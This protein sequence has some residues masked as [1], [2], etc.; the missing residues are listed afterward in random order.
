MSKKKEDLEAEVQRLL[1]MNAKTVDTKTD[2]VKPAAPMDNNK[3]NKSGDEST[4]LL[5]PEDGAPKKPWYAC[6]T[7]SCG[8]PFNACGNPLSACGSC[9]SYVQ[10]T[11]GVMGSWIAGALVALLIVYLSLTFLIPPGDHGDKPLKFEPAHATSMA[12]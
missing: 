4:P 12:S 8:N 6:C 1:A 7:F 11:L 10:S 2:A 9:L 3:S 5:E